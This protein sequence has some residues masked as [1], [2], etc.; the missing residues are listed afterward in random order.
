MAD[1][2]LMYGRAFGNSHEAQRLYG[3]A[4]PQRRLPD[5]RTFTAIDQR[6]RENGTFT[7]KTADWGLERTERVLDAETEILDIVEEEPGISA[8]RL[9]YRVGISMF[10][11][12]RTLHNQGLYP[13]HVQRVHTLKPEDLPRRMRFC[14]WLFERNRADLRFVATIFFT[15]ESTFTRD[16]IFNAR[17]P[18]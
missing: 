12:W 2:H 5:H 6:L 9:S 4:F 8:R 15:D 16:G 7:P 3:E 14:E 17:N 18:Y 10:V 1:M 13:Y 11:V